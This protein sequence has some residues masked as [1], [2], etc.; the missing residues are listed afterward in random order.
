MDR[1][2]KMEEPTH[3]S[4]KA[5]ID[6]AESRFEAFNARELPTGSAESVLERLFRR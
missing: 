2:D 5:W 1:M 6:D 4:D 3:P